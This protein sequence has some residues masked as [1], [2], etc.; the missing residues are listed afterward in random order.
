MVGPRLWS[1]WT[2]RQ[3]TLSTESCQG[4]WQPEETPPSD[5]AYFSETR[6]VRLTCEQDDIGLDWRVWRDAAHD[7]AIAVLGLENRTASDVRLLRLTPLISTGPDG[8][9][10]VG[11][12]PARLRI[13]DNGSD[14]AADVDVKLHYPDEKRN[15]LVG[16]LLPI[17]SRGAI[18]SNW[19]HAIDNVDGDGSWV[20][21]ALSV[22]RAFPTLGT[23][24]PAEDAPTLDGTAGL[25]LVADNAMD[26]NGKLLSAGQSVDSEA[27][28]FAPLPPDAQ[29]GLESYADAVAAFLDF[30]PWSKRD[31]GRPVPN[32]WNSWTGSGSTGGLGTDINETNMGENLDVMAREFAPFGV[33]YFQLDD[34]YQ[35]ADGDWFPRPD[36]FPNGMEAWSKR[37]KD[38]GLIP[39]LWIS[40]FTVSESSTLAKEHPELL[41]NPDDNV[42]GGLLGGD[43][44]VLDLSND[45]TLDYL[46][47]TLHRY[48]DDWGMGWIKLDFAYL[49]FPYV[50]RHAPELTSVEVYKRAIRKFREV[51]GDDVYYMGIALMGVNYGVVDCMR[52]TLDT[53]PRWEEPDPFALLGSG[54]NFK[55]SVKSAARRYYL[56]GRV[57]ENHDDL[58]FFRTDASQPEPAVTEQEATTLASF[59][60]LAGSIVKF[61]EDLRTLTP[62]QIQIWRK[63]LPIYPASA[64]P[65]DLFTRMY[66]E[67]W[68]LEIDGTLAGSDARWTVLGL[69]NW[70][71]N[72]DYTQDLTA[73]KMPDEARSYDVGLSS[74]GLDPNR[75]Y[76]ASEFWSEQFLGVV[77]SKLTT[78]VPA[79]GHALIALREASGHPQYLGDNRHFTQG[80][81]DLASESWDAASGTLTLAFDVDRGSDA[82]VPFEY[83]FRVYVPEGYTLDGSDVGSATVSQKDRVVTVAL[84]PASAG[85]VELK[86]VFR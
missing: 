59:I 22:E 80:A 33:D 30:T 53:G 10:F 42:V 7:T 85:P 9:L 62:E 47:D 49:A 51:L 44:R 64:R 18:V 8:G 60:G 78:E 75:D 84:T 4:G 12:D 3:R 27:M 66:P 57:W 2:A 56:H 34:G 76:L 81:T 73:E 14:V 5:A 40:A 17:E 15:N 65:L 52:T 46:N 37:V 82:A 38:K 72:W 16:A 68:R 79:H 28:Y 35:I 71:R 45:A 36:R 39:G 13:L 41:A 29:S 58:L 70:G 25:E 74:L 21:G 20:A 67:I 48:K 26:F 50:P 63:L 55:S 61:G 24:L 54:G 32:G 11:G 86:L 1:R 43:T 83:R 77:R 19:G 23:T 6:G 69:L 31:G